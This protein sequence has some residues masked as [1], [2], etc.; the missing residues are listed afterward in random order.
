M[1]G[2]TRGRDGSHGI[3]DTPGGTEQRGSWGRD[4]SH[5]IDDTPGGTVAAPAA[6]KG[7]EKKAAR[8]GRLF[9]DC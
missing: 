6:V 2:W 1:T 4:G 7:D 5:G 3:D 8:E 9:L